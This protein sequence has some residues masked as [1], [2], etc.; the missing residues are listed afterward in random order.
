M[1]LHCAASQGHVEIVRLLLEHGADKDAKSNVRRL[2]LLRAPGAG[3]SRAFA[4]MCF[5]CCR[6]TLVRQHVARLFAA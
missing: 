5:S 3:A 1:P 6:F 4:S 2:S